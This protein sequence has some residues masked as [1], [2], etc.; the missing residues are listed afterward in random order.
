MEAVRGHDST[1]HHPLSTFPGEEEEQRIQFPG[2]D[3]LHDPHQVETKDDAA[4]RIAEEKRE[5]R[6]AGIKKLMEQ[7]WFRDFLMEHLA[8]LN[9]FGMTFG[10]SPTGF[11]DPHAT[12]F[13]AGMKAAGESLFERIDEITP[14]LAALMRREATAPKP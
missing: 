1:G 6:Q 4:A 14:E 7:R 11:P 3:R 5:Q 9:T 8:S 12:F 10:V 2:E 13:H